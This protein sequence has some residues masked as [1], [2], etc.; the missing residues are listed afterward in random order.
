M[1]GQQREMVISVQRH[2]NISNAS[3]KDAYVKKKNCN[4]NKY[5]VVISSV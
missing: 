2:K 3:I 1:F 5:S 4:T